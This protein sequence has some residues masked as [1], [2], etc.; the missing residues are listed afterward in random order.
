MFS[1]YLVNAASKFAQGLSLLFFSGP[2]GANLFLNQ[3]L[4]AYAA[5]VVDEGDFGFILSLT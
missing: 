4:P 5:I 2:S 3:R 1:S